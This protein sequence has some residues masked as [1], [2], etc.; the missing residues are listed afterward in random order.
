MVHHQGEA[1]DLDPK[2]RHNLDLRP[3]MDFQ[4]LEIITVPAINMVL[5]DREMVDRSIVTE[6]RLKMDRTEEIVHKDHA[7]RGRPVDKVLVVQ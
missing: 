3:K 4:G 7:G 1:L 5:L 2:I 6:R